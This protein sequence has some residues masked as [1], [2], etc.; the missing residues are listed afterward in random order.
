MSTY[1]L[2]KRGKEIVLKNEN[3]ACFAEIFAA[4]KPLYL[5]KLPNWQ[6]LSV[7][8]VVDPRI[9]EE[10]IKKFLARCRMFSVKTT[11]AKISKEEIPL[12]REEIK[13]RYEAETKTVY[14]VIV[15]FSDYDNLNFVKFAILVARSLIEDVEVVKEYVKNP[16]PKGIQKWQFFK[17]CAS[18]VGSGNGH[19]Y[20][21]GS[22]FR[23]YTGKCCFYKNPKFSEVREKIS[24]CDFDRVAN[25]SQS[26]A[27]A[28]E[29][30]A[31]EIK[32][33]DSAEYALKLTRELNQ[34][35]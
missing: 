7:E 2:L 13:N 21:A 9:S 8:F 18:K 22:Y 34:T 6:E 29:K 24:K 33:L 25:D 4:F 11:L 15:K 32:P 35:Y 19:G 27:V 3:D 10:E 14:K 31:E 16:V 26:S 28:E 5:P 30:T 17:L 20:F 23:S 1:Y 12:W